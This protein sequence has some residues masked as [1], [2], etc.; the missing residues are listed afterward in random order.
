MK[1]RT[2]SRSLTWTGMKSLLIVLT[3]LAA[4]VGVYLPADAAIPAAER[5]A[6]LDLYT[7][8]TGAGWTN[9]TNWNGAAGTECTWYGVTCDAGVTHVTAISLNSN[10]LVGPLPASIGN[11]SS[12]QSLMLYGNQLT[13]AIPA[14]LGS[15][16]SLQDI[17]L[18]YN[19][20]TGAIPAALGSLTSLLYLDLR[21][22]QLTG[23]IPA[24]LGSLT[25]LW[26]L[27][28]NNNQLS[29]AIPAELGS[30]TS[31][32]YLLLNS[33]QLTG[34]IPAALGNLTSLQYLYLYSNQL[35]GAIPAE[36]G[37]LTSLQYLYLSINQLTG[38]IPAELGNLTSLQ[39]LFLNNNLLTGAIPAALGSL[40]SLQRLFLSSNQLT[41]AIPAVLGSL[42]S[43]R[44]LYLNNN[45]LTGAIPVELGSLTSL[46]Y[47][48]LSGNQLTG[49]IPAS[50]AS[51][52]ALIDAGS[53]IRWNALYTTD[54]ALK[55][56]LDAKQTG[57]ND[58]V[59]TQTIAPT[60]LGVSGATNTS[61]TLNWTP[62]AYTADTGG[63]EVYYS[64]SSGGSY[65]L[66]ETT[67][68]KSAASSTVTGLLA[69][70]TYYFKIRTKTNSHAG[71]TN[72][73][74]SEYTA[75]ISGITGPNIAVTDSVAPIG[76][77]MIPFGNVT[78][79]NTSDQTVTVTN[80]GNADLVIGTV[81]S[82][83]PIAAPFSITANNCSGQTIA[84]AGTCTLTVRFAPTAVG[85]ASD[86]FDIPSS[87]PD[88]ATVTIGLSGT[89]TM[90]VSDIAVTDGITPDSDLQMAFG[91]V[92]E[93]VSSPAQTITIANAG[94]A[95]LVVSGIQLSG[96]DAG[97]FSI[98]LN[99][100]ASPCA[101]ATPTVA[102]GG[103]CTVSVTFSP[104][105]TGAKNATAA[106]SSNDPDEA[107]VNVSL[108]GTGL[109]ASSNNAPASPTLVFPANGQ[110]GLGT[111]VEFRWKKAADPDGDTVTYHLSYCTDQN[112]TGCTP[113]DVASNKLYFAGFGMYGGMMIF[114]MVF[115]GTKR[116]RNSMLLLVVIVLLGT[117]ALLAACGGG[118]GSA[119]SVTDEMTYT[120]SG[121][122][123]G[124][125][126]Y[127]KVAAD[128]GNGGATES[129]VWSFSTQ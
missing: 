97:Q 85:A 82:A 33:N 51:L 3:V 55:T 100:G 65:N 63:Y 80:S 79:G 16:T 72:T 128:D 98:N 37:S 107:T 91:D 81:A 102:A 46:Q 113:V 23:A 95:D 105:S 68:N 94:T 28:L 43:L 116:G 53:D 75:E 2:G 70:N 62:I 40:T 38:A 93:G 11:F 76:D 59:S 13:G 22:N 45:Q 14:E 18:N 56:F 110:T 10:N 26:Y 87:D 1:T 36:L 77:F 60:N 122:T 6:L 47:L 124:T 125:T 92:T 129:A 69:G 20:L 24:A 123:A 19:Q 32:Q 39:Y 121:L 90:P 108:S 42:T 103:S 52:T 66:F 30:L 88:T 27:G 115:A 119:S 96:T 48:Y 64:T 58:W 44:Y 21:G 109:S 84:P 12:L 126:Y 118:G 5:T 41:G 50:F 114:G 71:N 67:A 106:I 99:G 120:A 4:V 117:G 25:S 74:Y 8:T 83:N 111:T 49:A 73:V 54:A 57:G 17:S 101:G 104:T 89:G 112:F 15:L 61:I 7:S 34:A 78:E 9:S 29:G 31:L 35:S 86:S 127:W